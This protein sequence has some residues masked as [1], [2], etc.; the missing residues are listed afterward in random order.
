MKISF[1]IFLRPLLVAPL[2]IIGACATSGGTVAGTDASVP[3]AERQ[4]QDGFVPFHWDPKQGKVWLEIERFDEEFLY[5]N[6]L[7]RGVGSNDLGLDR[8]QIGNVRVLRFQRVGPKVLLVQPNYDY[9]AL[10][11]NA[12]ERRAIEESFASSVLWAFDIDSETADAVMVDATA[13][14]SRD[15]H[16]LAQRLGRAKEGSYSVDAQRSV[17]YAPRSKAFPRN[18]EIEFIV[19]FAGQASGQYVPQVTPSSDALTV[20]MHHS[21]VALPDDNYR[22][23]RFDPRSGY[24][25]ISF[26]DYASPIE[27]PLTTR[28]IARHR[29]QK[30]NP[31]A[32]IS[33]AVEPIVY[34]VD[35]GAPS[36]IRE[37][38]LDGARWWADAFAELGYKDAFRVE[39]LPP[40][41]DPL[42]VRYNVIQWV[43][44]ATRGWSYGASVIDP[45]T[46][47]I[48]KGHVSLG[49]LRVR[50][51]F[52]LAEGLLAPYQDGDTA[53]A[54]LKE[55]ALARLRQLSAH[56]VGHTLGLNHN[57][58][59][60]AEN[61]A[62]VMD[63]PHPLVRLAADGSV[64]ISDAYDTGVGAWDKFAIRY[65]YQEFPAGT[66]ETLALTRIVADSLA[67]GQRYVVDADARTAGAAHPLGHLW[68]NGADP[69]AELRRIM[70]IRSQVLGKF[71]ENN[72]PSG[73]PLATLEEVLVPMYL[74]HRYQA[75]AAAK[76][77]GGQFYTYALRGD[78]QTATRQ[79]EA[80]TQRAA[81][82]ALLET[83][84]P[85]ALLL[86][87]S[88]LALIPGRPPGYWSHRE[89]F[90][91][92]TG[93]VFD[94]FAPAAAAAN[95]TVSLL[96][97]HERANRLVNFHGLDPS[98]PSLDE[99]LE[100]IIGQSWKANRRS[101]GA[102]VVQSLV[103]HAVLDGIMRLAA[104]EQASQ[105][106]RA[107]AYASL[108]ALEKTLE[109]RSAR[110]SGPA[111]D[112]YRYGRL[113][114]QRFLKD[115]EKHRPAVA[116]DIPPGSPIGDAAVFPLLP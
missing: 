89:L 38:L 91:R 17:F 2:L 93:P 37:A 112:H 13:F 72:I 84:Q 100:Q 5:V 8:G 25:G 6:Y 58:A 3:A 31:D 47:E 36:P 48:I 61:R 34:Y 51:D 101:G 33:E 66:D 83:L 10:S 73:A 57:F 98:L 20:H 27:A 43:H 62:S 74:M 26:S 56:E 99:V 60:S 87:E 63:Y 97:Q 11:D 67:R 16:G 14:L 45:R 70:T 71:S 107:S 113:R 116:P 103:D 105:P 41:A 59:A 15:A 21:F 88:L 65:G 115:P 55:M 39:V 32:E 28:Y 95:L 75:A 46:G 90:A 78:G 18:T 49:S 77:L 24:F 54:A 86:P 106:A 29:L 64:D 22:P 23:R 44:R 85:D 52:L 111:A 1:P 35:P 94:A 69:V 81:L 42:D 96:L 7:A 104:N 102:S 30:K 82:A 110:D 114:I 76:L 4:R 19:T 109:R 9:R 80:D 50:Q 53:P 40:D 79:I 92:S 12:E 108:L 68:D